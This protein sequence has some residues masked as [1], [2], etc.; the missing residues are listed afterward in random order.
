MTL[1]SEWC[2]SFLRPGEGKFKMTK[3]R[4]LI[5][6]V[7]VLG[8]LLAM[9]GWAAED[10]QQ[11]L[12][13]ATDL[14]LK[15]ATIEDL[16]EVA[17][18]CEEA[19]AKG[20]NPDDEA[21]AKKLLTGSLYQRVRPQCELI[22]QARRLSREL[23]QRRAELLA[24]VRKIIKYDDKFGQAY[25]MLA[26]LEGLEG[27]DRNEARK[28]IDRAV[29][30]LTE[31][32]TAL[33]NAILIRGQLQESEEARVAD[34]D[35]AV[36]LDPENPTVWQTRAL[37][38]LAKGDLKKAIAD[39]NSLLAKDGDNMLARLA[40][41]QALINV[42]EFEEAMK[43]VNH[44]IEKQPNVIALTLRSTLD[45]GGQTRQGLGRCGTGA[46]AGAA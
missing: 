33:V 6:K 38:F 4:G 24:D 22:V 18:L 46:V 23:Q 42:D 31:D 25:L 26:Q 40:V 16:G 45:A 34:F 44:V 21:F 27:G 12:D 7:F 10:G 3:R 28:A 14:K 37:Y 9:P 35:R 41:A 43:N 32:N 13:K 17:R 39:F 20:L 5:P 2:D 8:L 15:A 11:D 30:L 1:R 29:E 19:M 36:E